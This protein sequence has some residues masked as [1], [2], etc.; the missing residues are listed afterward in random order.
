MSGDADSGVVHGEIADTWD[1][2]NRLRHDVV[3]LLE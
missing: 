1:A 3:Q 2:A